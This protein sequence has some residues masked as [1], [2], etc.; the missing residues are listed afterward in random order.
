MIYDNPDEVTK[1]P[2]ESLLDRYQIKLKT[3]T[4]GS[5]FILNCVHGNKNAILKIQIEVDQ[6]INFPDW[7]KKQKSKNQLHQYKII[8]C[9]QYGVKSH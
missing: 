6:I 7:I 1:E 2:F 8:K 5:N 4:R 9:F 3:S